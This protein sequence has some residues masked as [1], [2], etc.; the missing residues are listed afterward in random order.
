MDEG[1]ILRVSQ[2]NG[3]TKFENFSEQT[4]CVNMKPIPPKR[5]HKTV[6]IV[7]AD[8]FLILE[9]EVDINQISLTFE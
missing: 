1:I 6:K 8:H 7:R 3:V 5:K 9:C 4:L 2:K